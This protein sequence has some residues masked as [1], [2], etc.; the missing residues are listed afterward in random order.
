ETHRASAAVPTALPFAAGRG[1]GSRWR[2][3]A[4]GPPASGHEPR[5]T[6]PR[7]CPPTAAG[8][9]GSQPRPRPGDPDA[10]PLLSRPS[11]R[12]AALIGDDPGRAQQGPGPGGGAGQAAGTPGQ[13]ANGP[14]PVPGHDAER[15]RGW[16]VTPRLYP[17]R[18]WAVDPQ[19]RAQAKGPE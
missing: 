6:A 13:V 7:G 17:P 8:A 15:P 10:A 1:R 2:L 3:L 18:P 14:I 9:P 12:E 5:D 11:Q 4:A 19:R 16:P